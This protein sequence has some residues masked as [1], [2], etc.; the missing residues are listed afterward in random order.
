VRILSQIQEFKHIFQHIQQSWEH[1]KD[2]ALLMIT[3]VKGSAYRRPGAK[4]MMSIDGSM[5]G[6]LSG[7]CL[8]ADLLGWA[9]KA[10]NEKTPRTVEYDL[11]ENALWGLGIGCKGTQEITIIPI[12]PTDS[13]WLK[14]SDRTHKDA[15]ITLILEIP[16]GL[17]GAFGDDDIG[18][19]DI[20]LL[21][22][23]VRQQ[24]A[25]H[26]GGRTRAE[27]M[28]ADGRRYVIDTL[29]P[30][31]RLIVAGAGHDAV[32]VVH[33][34]S[35]TGFSVTVLDPRT[36]FNNSSRFPSA[37]H[38]VMEPS[39]G[40]PSLFSNCSWV[41]MN[42]HQSRDEA[43]LQLAIN[44]MPRFI[45]I[46]GPLSRTEQML[47]SLNL[48]MS[49]GPIHSPVGLD[50]GAETIDEVALSIASQL[51]SIRNNRF[52]APLHGRSKIHV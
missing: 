39:D 34:A 48:K 2:A 49:D 14:T 12:E 9:E 46:L 40:Y 11:T 37:E 17:R 20:D 36:N 15:R 33:L 38:A 16:S 29:Q 26:A 8:E 24:A 28:E 30:S 1:G 45:G 5:F 51:I 44:S 19:G 42:H 21:P 7:G 13:F 35:K 25:N 22:A 10:I 27:M 6:T 52:A 23:K 4:M 47:A 50:L 41:I 3:A 18:W 32:P 31:E 43:S